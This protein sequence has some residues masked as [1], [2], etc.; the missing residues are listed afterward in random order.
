ME[1][2]IPFWPR[3]A[4]VNAV[5]VN[6][7]YIAELG[8]CFAIVAMVLGMMLT[9]C[10]RYRRG[11]TASRAGRVEKTWHF[12]IGWTTATLAAFLGLFVWGAAIYIWLYQSDRGDVEI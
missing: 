5:A 11:S 1:H 8:V 10:I 3:T 12:E 9:F 7:L 6:N 2:W 4:A